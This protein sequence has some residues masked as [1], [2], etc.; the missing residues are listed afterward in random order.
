[1]LFC[2]E[3]AGLKLVCNQALFDNFYTVLIAIFYNIPKMF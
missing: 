1:M 2:V 3:I